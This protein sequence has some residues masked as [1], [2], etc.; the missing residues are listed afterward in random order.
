MK[1]NNK[2]KPRIIL[3]DNDPVLRGVFEECYDSCIGVINSGQASKSQLEFVLMIEEKYYEDQTFSTKMTENLIQT[4]HNIGRETTTQSI[5]IGVLENSINLNNEL[6]SDLGLNKYFEDIRKT[7]KFAKKLDFSIPAP[8]LTNKYKKDNFASY[9]SVAINQLLDTARYNLVSNNVL[10]SIIRRLKLEVMISD[11][12]NRVRFISKNL[13]SHFKINTYE[14]YRTK[15]NE[16][17][18]DYEFIESS[19]PTLDKWNNVQLLGLSKKNQNFQMISFK[20]I[21]ESYQVN[22]N[23]HLFRKA[24]DFNAELENIPVIETVNSLIG[25]ISTLLQNEVT[26]DLKD[27]LLKKLFDLKEEYQGNLQNHLDKISEHTDLIDFNNHLKIVKKKFE[28]TQNKLKLT[29]KNEFVSPFLHDPLIIENILTC[30][31]NIVLGLLENNYSPVAPELCIQSFHHFG[32]HINLTIGGLEKFD[33]S[34]LSFIHKSPYLILLQQLAQAHQFNVET[35]ILNNNSI[36][37]K[38]ILLLNK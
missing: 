15:I 32:I 33:C 35:V 9:T 2:L 19:A 26:S 17:I 24:N 28:S 1:S 25:Q 5:L 4:V 3:E 38:S 20:S 7:I 11:E 12:Q 21:S 29:I 30:K 22:E 8:M 36:A 16:L 27:S 14:A 13:L 37:I 10:N 23:I 18:I 31:C 34:D 6:E